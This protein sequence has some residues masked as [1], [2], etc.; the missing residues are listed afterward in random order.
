MLG[1]MEQHGLI[2]MEEI[3]E[4]SAIDRIEADLANYPQ[5]DLP[6]EH[7]FPPGMYVRKIFMPAGS[8]VVSMKHKTTHPFFILK[9]KVAVLKE[10]EN[11]GF[12]QE[13]LYEGGDMGIT[14]PNTKRFLWNVEDTTWVTCHANP[15]DIEDPD[16]IVLNIAERTDNP[17]IDSNSP[18][19]N[20]WRKDVSPSLI[21]TTQE[22]E[23]Q[24]V[25]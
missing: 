19:F 17:L 6:L 7:F 8:M 22:L 15:N 4:I 1:M 20:Q 9:G 11:G 21:H 18:K 13:A 3:V 25:S 24:C 10:S 16:E 14:T 23:F 5:V 12:E 2:D